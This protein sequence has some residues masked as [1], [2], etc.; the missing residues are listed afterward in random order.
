MRELLQ[1]ALP[2]A[3]ERRAAVGR[4]LIRTRQRVDAPAIGK[5]GIGRNAFDDHHATL[6][7]L[8][9]V[10]KTEILSRP[11]ILTRSSQQATILVGHWTGTLDRAQL[12]RVLAGDDPFDETTM[13]DDD[14]GYTPVADETDP[15][16]AGR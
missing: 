11:S 8:A 3:L 1:G 16:T 5:I 9:S 12:D 13:V 14:H 15:V 2:E 10:N 6:H 7:A 4:A